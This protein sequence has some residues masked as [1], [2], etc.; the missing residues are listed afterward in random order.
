MHHRH[1]SD[2][3]KNRINL[4]NCLGYYCATHEVCE[5]SS[6]TTKDTHT[7]LQGSFWLLHRPAHQHYI[8]A[9]LLLL[10]FGAGP[11]LPPSSIQRVDQILKVVLEHVIDNG[12]TNEKHSNVRSALTHFTCLRVLL[13][14]RQ[15]FLRKLHTA[16]TTSPDSSHATWPASELHLTSL[17]SSS[18]R[19]PRAA[20]RCVCHCLGL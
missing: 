14:S 18:S 16:A 4:F 7:L 1:G 11:N 19:H 5:T 8:A 6:I 10:G 3:R 20:K 17:Q 12:S 9:P 13:V 15:A 2:C